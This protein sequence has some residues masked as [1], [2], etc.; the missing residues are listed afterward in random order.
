MR[1]EQS[2]IGKR[3][4][5]PHGA[6]PAHLVFPEAAPCLSWV[7]GPNRLTGKQHAASR[8]GD[9]VAE[10][11]V[12]R[13]RVG[14]GFE[15]ANLG[16]PALRGGDG[17]SECEAHTL[18]PFGHEHTREKIAR[19]PDS[20]QLRSKILL[21]DTSIKAGDGARAFIPEWRNGFP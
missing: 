1:E 9:A 18:R 5:E 10:L 21:R 7:H 13:V 3:P 11:V 12:V 15:T 20:F 4:A 8:F 19:C 17:R 14:D 16:E 6:R 2:Q